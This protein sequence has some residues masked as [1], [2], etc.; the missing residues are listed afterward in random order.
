MRDLRRGASPLALGGDLAPYA[1]VLVIGVVG[2]ERE[3]EPNGRGTMRK[4]EDRLALLE[5]T[6]DVVD[7]QGL[8]MRTVDD[9]VL[10]G[11]TIALDGR[12]LLS[13]GS[14]SYLGLELDARMRDGVCAAVQRYGTQF[15]SS[16]SYLSAAPYAELE[17]RLEEMFGRHVLVAPSTTLGH[18]AALPV[19]VGSTDAI[20]LDQQVHHSVR[21]A[22]DQLRVQGTRVEVVRH[23]RMDRLEHA[24]ERLAPRHRRVWYLADGVYSMYADLAPFD[25]LRAMLDRHETLHLYLDDSHGIGWAGRHGRG[26]ALEA[27]GMHERL[28]VAASLNK[29]FAAAGA[30]LVFPDAATRRRVRMLGGPMMFSGPVQPPMLGAALTSATIHLSPELEERQA[31]LRER[32]VHL[33]ELLEGLRLPSASH[34][35]TPIRYLTL[36]MPTIAQEVAAR[37]LADGI[38]VNLAMFPAVPMQQAGLRLALSLHHDLEDIRTLADAL[39]RHVPA[40]LAH[41]EAS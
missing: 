4:A 31:A 41:G 18:L 37:L 19:L 35:R 25:E 14:C 21:M 6:L 29:S 24:I 38:Y 32:V 27:L 2:A 17:A 10:D 9:G 7:R 20:V 26:L 11:R 36:G 8:M 28:V 39:A 30:A 12:S 40:T 22:A 1:V 3:R 13:F 5:E 34:E 23:N 33:T 15:S 16:R